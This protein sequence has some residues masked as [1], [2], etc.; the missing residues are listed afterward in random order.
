VILFQNKTAFHES[1]KHGAGTLISLID[2]H[3]KLAPDW[4]IW[5]GQ[6][7]LD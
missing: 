5:H 3:H 7:F 6:L 1:A 4:L 2:L